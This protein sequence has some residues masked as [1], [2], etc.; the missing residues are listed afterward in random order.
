MYN[1]VPYT[2]FSHNRFMLFHHPHEKYGLLKI[3]HHLFTISLMN[4]RWFVIRTYHLVTE[5][6]F[7]SL[8]GNCTYI[9]TLYLFFILSRFSIYDLWLYTALSWHRM[10]L[11]SFFYPTTGTV[12]KKTTNNQ[13]RKLTSCYLN[14][15]QQ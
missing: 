13:F 9:R 7:F 10:Y 5:I 6:F 15:S 2:Y 4:V 11:S 8:V 12:I 1:G 3:V 14:N